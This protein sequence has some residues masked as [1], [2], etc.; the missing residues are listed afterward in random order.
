M[1]DPEMRAQA[2][3]AALGLPPE[4]PSDKNKNSK[5][6][7]PAKETAKKK[8]TKDGGKEKEKPPK[9]LPDALKQVSSQSCH[10]TKT[11][12]KETFYVP[13]ECG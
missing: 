2:K 9:T 8:P 10:V 12:T 13:V 4:K 3:R 1:L 11:I 6:A 5:V 7:A